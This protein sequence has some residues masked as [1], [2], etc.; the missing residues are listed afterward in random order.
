MITILHPNKKLPEMTIHRLQRYAIILMGY[1]YKIRYRP[2]GQHS[3]ADCLSRLPVGPDAIF[4]EEENDGLGI[5]TVYTAVL[6]EF[7]IT[8]KII[9][10]ASA[11]DKTMQKVFKYIQHGWPAKISQN[12]EDYHAIL[13]YFRRK[14]CLCVCANV[15]IL[16]SEYTR[17]G[18]PPALQKKVLFMLHQGHWGVT[19]MKQLSRRYCWWPGIDQDIE[20]TAASCQAC[21]LHSSQSAREYSSWPVPSSPW[22]RVHLDY[23]GHFLGKMWLIVVDAFSKFPWVVKMSS[24]TTAATISA[25][26]S[27]FALEGLP[28]TLV[29]DNGTQFVSKEFEHFGTE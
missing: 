25:L 6:E 24:S 22:D 13:P 27:I 20:M 19:R 16:Q 23:A 9:A 18:I 11:K 1:N 21:Q 29:S 7:P 28:K 2:T 8:S 14:L 26:R 3:N 15:L 10:E 4:D 12:S 17:V 5:E